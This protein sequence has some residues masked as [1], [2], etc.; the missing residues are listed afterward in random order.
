MSNSPTGWLDLDRANLILYCRHWQDTVDFYRRHLG[1]PVAFENDWFVEFQLT[2]D[3]FLSI[4]DSRRASIRDVH[5][6][7]IT[8]TL[9]VADVDATQA[10]LQDRGIESTPIRRKWDALVFYCYDPE[11]HRLEFWQDLPRN[12][13]SLR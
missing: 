10:A 4:A 1:L 5:G 8:L 11:G 12:A 6:Q 13:R 3:A 7:G 2:P 9:R